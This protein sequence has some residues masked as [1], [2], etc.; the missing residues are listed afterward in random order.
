MSFVRGVIFAA[1]VG[2]LVWLSERFKPES[3]PLDTIED[4]M[5]TPPTMDPKSP[6]Q[7]D[8]SSDEPKHSSTESFEVIEQGHE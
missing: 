8:P 6:P 5:T 2:A 3:K 1:A 4:I 7:E